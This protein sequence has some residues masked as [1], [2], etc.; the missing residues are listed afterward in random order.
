MV[1]KVGT[2]SIANFKKY[3]SEGISWRVVA[4]SLSD[5]TPSTPSGPSTQPTR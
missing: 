2:Y 3:V 4:I 5:S 1:G